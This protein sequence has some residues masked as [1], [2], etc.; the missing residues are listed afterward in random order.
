MALVAMS[1]TPAQL[2]QAEDIEDDIGDV[3]ESFEEETGEGVL[4]TVAHY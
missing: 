3:L 1:L 2:E 4:H